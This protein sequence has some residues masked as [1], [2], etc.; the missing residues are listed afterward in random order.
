ML[1]ALGF[2]IV[3]IFYIIKFNMSITSY[4]NC[5]YKN[6]IYRISYLAE[7]RQKTIE[8]DRHIYRKHTIE[9]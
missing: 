1:T 6:L 4:R 9:Y 8:F 3:L 7:I 5:F 2:I